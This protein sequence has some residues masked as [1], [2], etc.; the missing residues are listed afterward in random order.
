MQVVY[1]RCAGLDVHQ[2][3]VSACVIVCEPDGKKRRQVRVGQICVQWPTPKEHQPF[4]EGM[5]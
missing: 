4:S 1:S 3:T 2:K 5:T